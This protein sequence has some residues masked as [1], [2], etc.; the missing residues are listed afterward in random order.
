MIPHFL[1]G[2]QHGILNSRKVSG[3]QIMTQINQKYHTEN[4]ILHGF[5]NSPI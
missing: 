2:K 5:I 3:G 1:L 4:Y